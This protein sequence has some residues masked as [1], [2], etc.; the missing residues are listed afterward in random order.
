MSAP[1]EDWN[2]V[3]AAW[4]LARAGTMTAAARMLGVHHSTVLRQVDRLE[5]RLGVRLFQRHS[6]GCAPTDAGR[7]LLEV[8]EITAE[9]FERLPARLTGP[10]AEIRGRLRVTTAPPL[11]DRLV[12]VAARFQARHP[13]A[14][15][16]LISDDRRLRLDYG[17]AHVSIRPGAAPREPDNVARALKPLQVALYASAD[18]VARLGRM[19]SRDDQE[20]RRFIGLL[21]PDRRNRASIWLEDAVSE[22]RI[23]F[24][25]PDARSM[26]DA[27]LAGLGVAPLPTLWPETGLEQVLPPQPDWSIPLWL[28]THRDSRRMPKVQAFCAVVEEMFGKGRA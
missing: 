5:A 8:A 11:A 20:G 19:E 23:A 17:E 13:G 26:R 9:Q 6:R 12:A 21:T 4:T 14:H 1:I 15:V 2:D 24:R 25:G 28:V 16:D 7:L 22:S 3:R 10:E 27:A 18:L